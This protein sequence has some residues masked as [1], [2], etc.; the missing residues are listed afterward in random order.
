MIRVFIGGSQSITKLPVT[1][2]AR[3]DK[4]VEKDF[5]VLKRWFLKQIHFFIRSPFSVR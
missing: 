1:V 3:I 4:I 2:A 5:T